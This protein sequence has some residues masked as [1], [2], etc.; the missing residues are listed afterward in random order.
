MKTIRP[1]FL[2]GLVLGWTPLAAEPWPQKPLRAIVPVAAGSTTDI[3]PRV[4]FDQLARDLGKPVVV[5]NR[6]GAG[7][8]IGAALVAKAE[9]DGYT[10]LVNSNAHTIAPAIYRQ[11]PYDP[12]QDFTGVTAL[13]ASPSVLIVSPA[14]GYKTVADLVA[15]AKGK[16]GA[17]NFSSVGIGTATHLSAERFRLSAGI[18]VVHVPFKGGA[19]AMNEVIA[20]RIDFFFGPVGLVLPAI[21]EGRL[22][23]LAV[24]VS[25]RARALPDVPTLQEAGFTDAEFPI[26][27]GLFAPAKT[28]DHVVA[29]LHEMTEKALKTPQVS[30]KLFALG[31]DPLPM[32]PTAFNAFV[33]QEL[34]LNARLVKAAGIAQE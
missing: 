14:S 1:L 19:E 20:R 29:R 21:R 12:A 25:E 32:T 16:P 26:W 2:V 34:V 15:A 3:V 6:A 27:F 5:E 9:P 18:D 33:R 22:V 24:N 8:T 10:L 31:V 4:I 23:P 17:L 30:D 13:G 7:G 11:L 28:P